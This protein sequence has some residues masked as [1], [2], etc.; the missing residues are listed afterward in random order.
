MIAVPILAKKGFEQKDAHRNALAVLLPVSI[1]SCAIY[2]FK[3]IVSF[4]DA[5]PYL[6]GGIA[7]ALAGTFIMTRISP[8]L[9]KGVFGGF[10]IYAGIRLL[11]K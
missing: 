3:G 4:S 6:P 1:I 8:K 9:L 5:L 10:M 11:L 7:G 2:I